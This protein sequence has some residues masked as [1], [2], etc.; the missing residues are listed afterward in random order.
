MSERVVEIL[1][2]IMSEMRRNDSVSGK[3][4][5]LSQDLLDR[6][7]T[8]SEISSAFTWL[9]DKIDGES[10]EVLQRQQSTSQYSFRHLHEI[11][12][13]II[14]PEA[15]GFIIQLKELAII[16]DFDFE[17]ILERALML[18]VSR[19]DLAQMKSLAS[20][21][22]AGSEMFIHGVKYFIDDQQTIQ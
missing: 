10:E 6:G 17:Q 2:Y 12:R 21:I 13:A 19:V 9:L 4:D 16:D 18:G 22:L 7:Y 14:T 5:I 8:E 3:L 11:E 20:S 1:I 15:Y